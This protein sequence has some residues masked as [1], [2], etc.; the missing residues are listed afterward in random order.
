VSHGADD[1]VRG[2]R[3]FIAARLESQRERPK[4]IMLRKARRIFG[5]SAP[6]LAEALQSEG[7]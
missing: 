1:R 2:P 5:R 3:D 7:S 4:I 6:D